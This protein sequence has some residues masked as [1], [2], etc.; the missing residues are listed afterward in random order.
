[1]KK[2][3][4]FLATCG[5]ALL[6]NATPA[7]AQTTPPSVYTSCAS[8]D[9]HCWA[10]TGFDRGKAFGANNSTAACEAEGQRAN[11]YANYYRSQPSSQENS[12]LILYWDYYGDGIYTGHSY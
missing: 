7:L 12:N 4:L 6:A 8:S 3:S 9:S 2:L 11:Q 10:D 5:L 1:M